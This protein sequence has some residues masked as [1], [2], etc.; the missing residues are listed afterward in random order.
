ME[1]FI[2]NSSTTP[3]D[4]NEDFAESSSSSKGSN[5]SSSVTKKSSSGTK[6]GDEKETC[7]GEPGKAWDGTTAKEFACGHGTKLNPY[8]ILTAEQLSKLSF[9]VGAKDSNYNSDSYTILGT[10]NFKTDKNF[11]VKQFKG[12]YRFTLNN[13][14]KTASIH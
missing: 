10:R 8:I 5:S 6:N 13:K 9:I 1:K 14:K 7:Q 3:I 12:F 2:R 4:D 11:K